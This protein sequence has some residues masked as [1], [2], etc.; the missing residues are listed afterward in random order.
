MCVLVE[1]ATSTFAFRR[2][3]AARYRERNACEAEG[4]DEGLQA[5]SAPSLLSY[6]AAWICGAFMLAYVGIESRYCRFRPV[7]RVC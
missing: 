1:L 2:E 6:P 3:D 7:G 5:P 4:A